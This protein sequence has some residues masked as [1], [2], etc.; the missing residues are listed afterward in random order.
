M[1]ELGSGRGT[2]GLDGLDPLQVCLKPT[3]TC[4]ATF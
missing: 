2:R 1:S 4:E 3:A